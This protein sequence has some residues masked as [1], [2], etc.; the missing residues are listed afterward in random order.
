MIKQIPWSW[1]IP[2][3]ALAGVA[4]TGRLGDGADDAIPGSDLPR[5][6]PTDFVC[7]P[8]LIPPQLP[9][10]RLSRLQYQNTIRAL[11]A[12]AA[13]ESSPVVLDELEPTLGGMVEDLLIG[14]DQHYARFA[15]RDQSLQQ[16]HANTLYAVGNELGRLL[17]ENDGILEETVGACATDGDASNDDTCLDELIRRFGERALRRPILEDDVT[18]YRDVAG[19]PPFEREDYADV[20]AM[21]V[22]APA[23]LFFLE[24]AADGESG[25]QVRVGPYA[26]ASRLSYHFWQSPPDEELLRV[27]RDGSILNDDVYEAQ[28]ARVFA[29]PRT[30]ESLRAFYHQWLANTTLADLSTRVGDPI[31]DAVRGSL[32]PSP[33]LQQAMWDEVVDAAV[34]YTVDAPGTFA[35]FFRSDLSFARSEELAS[36]YGVPA[37]DGESSPPSLTDRAGLVSRAAFVATGLYATRPIM[38]GVLL[39]KAIL[40]DVIPPV[41]D[42]IP[43]VELEDNLSTREFTAGLTGGGRCAGCHQTLINGLGFAT[44]N[45]D[46]LGRSRTEEPVIDYE[47]GDVI[48]TV[49]IDTAATPFVELDDDRPVRG[50]TELTERILESDKPYA[51]F[52]RR[53]VQ[54]T[55]GRSEH[56]D[57]DGC[58]LESIKEAAQSDAQTL[59]DALTHVA[60]SD[61]FKRRSFVQ[62]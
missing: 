58:M 21:L 52:A 37:W 26:L 2:W 30:H 19:A 57:R 12:F 9:A 47:T 51:C 35:D 8:D 40:C 11:T 41:P 5:S 56:L 14:E 22:N 61:A 24:E 20:F 18:F 53:Y 39:R 60:R 17:T 46:P 54:Y 55:M 16:N 10:R 36:I 32:E 31:Y 4:C 7:D 33:E 6:T 28:L 29:D 42:D 27:A 15:R 44:E 62:E 50:A 45:F 34:Y 25:D 59:A 23:M 49:A 1:V 43:V 38:K 3:T 13:P 48:T